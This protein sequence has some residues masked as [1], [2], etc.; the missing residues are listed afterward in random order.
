MRGKWRILLFTTVCLLCCPRMVHAQEPVI[1]VID[2]GHGGKNLGAQY[3]GYVEKDMTMVTAMAMKEELERYENVVVYLTHE[4][5]TDL[6]IKARAQFAREKEADFLFCLHYNSSENH[7]FY[8]AEVW[9][10]AYG[11]LYAKG[12]AF[13]EIE[14][15]QLTEMGLYSRG[16]KTRLNDRDENYY[17]ILRYCSE[18]D[19][20][21]ALIEH[22]HLD[23]PSDKV[24]YQQSEEQLKA[25]GRADGTAA[26]KYLGLASPE[27]GVDYG[28]Y[29]K[30]NVEIREDAVRPD[31]SGPDVCA[32]EVQ[33]INEQTGEL[34]VKIEASDCESYVQYYSYSLDGGRTFSRLEPWPRPVWYES[35]PEHVFTADIPLEQDLELCVNAYNGF[36]FFTESNHIQIEAVSP[37]GAEEELPSYEELHPE[38]LYA[39]DLEGTKAAEQNTLAVLLIFIGILMILVFLAM[40]R[41]ILRLRG[42]N[43]RRR[44]R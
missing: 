43:R 16:I 40:V 6:S 33:K 39:Q 22:C 2:P 14:M 23:H 11:S 30:M 44:R 9:V 4:T 29:P 10:P 25:F 36:D 38:E 12:R 1:I 42:S 26:A 34:T 17:G 37:P 15:E 32:I 18:F 19:I 28:G 5:D 13:A 7:N 27:L 21:S 31:K 3:D 24:F 41:M 35:A 8:G 20:P